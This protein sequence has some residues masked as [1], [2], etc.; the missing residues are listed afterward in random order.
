MQKAA[1]NRTLIIKVY[2]II[3]KNYRLTGHPENFKMKLYY[4]QERLSIRYNIILKLLALF[5][6]CFKQNS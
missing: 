4:F 1:K 2:Y 3:P 6:I 5:H